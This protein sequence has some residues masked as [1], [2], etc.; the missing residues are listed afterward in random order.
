MHKASSVEDAL[1]PEQLSQM[2]GIETNTIPELCDLTAHQC[3]KKKAAT[4]D[5]RA[6][7]TTRMHTV[8]FDLFHILSLCQRSNA[9][10]G[11]KR[12]LSRFNNV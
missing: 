3:N 9:A 7:L 1:V 12:V 10:T 4:N 2:R 6:Q 8:S 5:Q 11:M